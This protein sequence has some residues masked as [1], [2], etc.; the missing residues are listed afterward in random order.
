MSTVRLTPGA[1]WSNRWTFIIAASGAT[2]GL[3]NIW[4][5]PY[6]TGEHGGGTFVLIYLLCICIV[7]LPIMMAETMLG[8]SGRHNPVMSIAVVAR[9][10][11]ASRL[12]VLIGGMSVITGALILSFYSVMAGWALDYVF[13]VGTGTFSGMNGAKSEA[14]F[15]ALIADPAW[16]VLWHSI[17][18]L[19][20]GIVI[21]YGINRGLK[22]C[23]HFIMPI[24]FCLLLLL[25]SYSFLETNSFTRGLNFMF[26]FD[27]SK[28][29]YD[30]FLVA[31]GHAFF[32]LSLGMGSIMAYGAY[33][34]ANTSI[35]RSVFTIAFLDT[36]V[37]LVSGLAI[38]PLVF[39]NALQPSSG[40]G[41]L[42]ISLPVAFGNLPAGSVAG[43]VFFILL[44]LAALSS[45][46]S[47]LEPSVAYVIEKFNTTRC[48]ATIILTFIIWALGLLSALSF[49]IMSGD[50]YKIFG[51][52]FFDMI[53][54]LTTNI[55]LPLSGLLISL[56]AGWIMKRS[57]AYNELKLELWQFNI[58]RALCRVIA[59]LCVITIFITNL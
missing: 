24:L 12:W 54:F 43:I 45:S 26:H 25:V 29:T 14:H 46:I 56:F 44:S 48:R 49:N 19:L 52:N 8:R 18:M 47:L 38:F 11:G 40:P 42:F 13:E 32:T 10:S 22:K 59:P 3:G 5:F 58:W 1:T 50:E 9:E 39:E 23:V 20:T 6:I 53:D 27:P 41:L 51:M 36:V 55:M 30:V 17:F 34:P 4:K 31:L 35:A 2:I 57:I 28:I 21:Y 33:M 15:N 7:G 16:M 37:A